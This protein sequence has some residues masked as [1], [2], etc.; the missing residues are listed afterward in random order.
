[1]QIEP[2]IPGLEPAQRAIA[3]K[4]LIRAS[5]KSL[6]DGLVGWARRLTPL[7]GHK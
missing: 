7:A 2:I 3:R 1:M 4:R 5:E 6:E